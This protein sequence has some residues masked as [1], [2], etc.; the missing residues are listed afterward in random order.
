MGNYNSIILWKQMQAH[1]EPLLISEKK[2]TSVFQEI[3]KRINPRMGSYVKYTHSS[4]DMY[5]IHKW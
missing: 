2:N 4:S 3:P 5:L 1:V